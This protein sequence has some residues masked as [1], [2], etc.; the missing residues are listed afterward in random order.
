MPFC[1]PI[2]VP[3]IIQNIQRNSKA[4]IYV[5]VYVSQVTELVLPW[6][7]QF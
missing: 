4:A 2:P 1:T 5:Y 7:N 3:S 6:Q